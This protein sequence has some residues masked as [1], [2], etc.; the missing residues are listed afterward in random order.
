[1]TIP[2]YDLSRT[3]NLTTDEHIV[4]RLN[5]LL[6]G[7]IVRQVWLMFLDENDV[8]LPVIMPCYLPSK[9]DPDASR[10]FA[11]TLR[12]FCD[13]VDAATAV[14][15]FERPGSRTVTARDRAWLRTL[16]AGCVAAQHP[17]RGPYLC[18][19]GGVV[20][21]PPDDYLGEP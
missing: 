19:D 5:S 21:V 18:H 12:E 8:Q 9:P 20:S 2:N 1:M 6:D 15:T 14:I 11:K 16:R 4:E 13:E 17:F 10:H 7:A 3:T